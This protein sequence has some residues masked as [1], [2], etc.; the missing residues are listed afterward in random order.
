MKNLLLK[1][2]EIT[3]QKKISEVSL[4]LTNDKEI[5]RLNKLYR[6][7]DS[8]TDVLA[9]SQVENSN[10]FPLPDNETEYLLGDI[11]ISI[12]TAQRQAALLENSL[13]YELAVLAVHGFLHLIGFDHISEEDT[14]RMRNM[15]KD[16]ID[17]FFL[18]LKEEPI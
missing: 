12:E 18:E 16:I 11:V 13:E 4:L 10:E 8:P 14:V 9:F 5:H 2:M 3:N 15:E 7:I 17:R 6:N 1:A